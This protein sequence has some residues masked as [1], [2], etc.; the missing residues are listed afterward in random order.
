M[1][2][3]VEYDQVLEKHS[4]LSVPNPMQQPRL[5]VNTQEPHLAQQQ[6]SDFELFEFDQQSTFDLCLGPHENGQPNSEQKQLV[7]SHFVVELQ[8]HSY[9]E[10]YENNQQNHEPNN[11]SSTNK[12]YTVICLVGKELTIPRWQKAGLLVKLHFYGDSDG[13]IKS[14]IEKKIPYL[15]DKNWRFYEC[16][17]LKPVLADVLID[18]CRFE[19]LKGISGTRKKLYIGTEYGPLLR[20]LEDIH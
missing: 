2:G 7:Q 5:H 11:I 17:S 8:Q 16:K 13:Q 12:E 6:L 9:L 18:K 10:P 19:H 4:G 15:K 1:Q 14:A 20:A 3:L